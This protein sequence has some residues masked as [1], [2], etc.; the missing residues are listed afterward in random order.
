M[1]ASVDKVIDWLDNWEQIK[2]SAIPIRFKE[3]FEKLRGIRYEVNIVMPD[4][5]IYTK[6]IKADY[7]TVEKN[8]GVTV[9][10]YRRYEYDDPSED[11]VIA[12][13]PPTA[14]ITPIN[15]EL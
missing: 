6:F 3:D 2:N 14:L 5:K 13:V 10:W 12:T 9:F 11:A 7:I 1:L 8:S 4:G 15:N